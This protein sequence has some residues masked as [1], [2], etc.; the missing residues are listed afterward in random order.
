MAEVHFSV[1]HH[2]HRDA[3]GLK[4]ST[5]LVKFLERAMSKMNRNWLRLWHWQDRAS[6]RIELSDLSDSVLRDIGMSRGNERFRPA[7]PFWIA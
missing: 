7:M 4:T 3:M 5:K 2:M 1:R 6:L